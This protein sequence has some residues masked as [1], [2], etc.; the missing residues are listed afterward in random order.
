MTKRISRDIARLMGQTLKRMRR[1]RGWTQAELAEL[2][3]T[4]K[5]YISAMENGRGIGKHM[6]DRLCEIFEVE[7]E[8]FIHQAIPEA[9][10]AIDKRPRVTLMI[11]EELETMPEYE[12]LRL[13]AEII[14]KRMKTL[15]GQIGQL[16]GELDVT[17]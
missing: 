6:L 4:H 8:A 9:S 1:E 10:Q 17:W 13:L 11:L 14:E 3:G 7:E 15:E 5:V 2:T 16:K 12:Q